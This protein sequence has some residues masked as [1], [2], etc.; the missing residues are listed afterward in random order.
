MF[1]DRR[2]RV[3]PEP[4]LLVHPE[5]DQIHHADTIEEFLHALEDLTEVEGD[6]RPRK[7][8]TFFHNMRGFD[9][10]FVLEALYDQGRAVEKPLTQGAK[11]LYFES[12]NLIFKDSMNF[13]AM[14]LENF[15]ATFNLRELHKGFFPH[16]FNREENFEYSGEYPPKED[17]HPDEMDSK[18]RDKFLA[19]HARKVAEQ[20]VFNFQEELLK[21]C[22]SDVKLLKEECLKF[23]A[24]FEEIAGF[25]PLVE[26]VTIASACNLFWRREKLEADLIALEPQGGWRGNRINQSKIA[27]EWLYY[28]DHLLGGMGRVRHV[29]NG[30]KVQ[31][32][33]PGEMVYVDGYDE[34]TH[35]IFEFYGCYYHGCPRCFKRQRDVRRNCHADR[36][37]NEV[38][39]ATERKAAMLRLCGYHVVEKWEC[40]FQ[41]EKKTDPTL[42]AFLDDLDMVPPLDPRDAFYGGRTGAV[43]LYAKAKE[44]ESIK[45][46]DVTSLYPWVNKYKEYPVRFPLIYTNPSDKEIDHYFGLAQVDI[47]APQHLFHPVLPDQAGGK[48]TFPLCSACVREEQQKPWL[49]RTNLFPHTDQERMLRGT[50]ATSEL[51]KA[52]ELGY[53]IV[54]IHEVW[55]FQEEDRRVGLFADYVNTWLKIKQESAGWPDECHTP[56]QKDAYLRDYEE[57]EGIRLEQVAKNPGR[58]QVAKM[59]LNR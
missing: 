32:G 44:G 51:Q 22:E 45:Y 52:V 30:G 46:C 41:E 13:F 59:M 37:V 11:I 43:S 23:V 57:K 19:W 38:Y 50:W 1:Y 16:A 6:E 14:A 58:K 4:H 47:L 15:P 56:E 26:A 34:T 53:R 17:Y 20:A 5:D 39:E 54:K 27:L 21:Y 42:K 28:Q 10:N 49:E 2:P 9:G 25:N 8:I 48:L 24:E 29:R 3:C 12:G 31:V 33:T 55:H 36:T 7:V 40:E 35:T 18:K